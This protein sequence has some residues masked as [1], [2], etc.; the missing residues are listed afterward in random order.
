VTCPRA[1][2]C[3][4]LRSLTCVSLAGPRGRE[5]CPAVS[6]SVCGRNRLPVAVPHPGQAFSP[7]E[8][9][10]AKTVAAVAAQCLTWGDWR[11][12]GLIMRYGRLFKPGTDVGGGVYPMLPDWAGGCGAAAR[13]RAT[14]PRGT[15]QRRRQRRVHVGFHLQGSSMS[16]GHIERTSHP[17]PQRGVSADQ[18]RFVVR[19]RI[20]LSTFRFSACRLVPSCPWVFWVRHPRTRTCGISV[21]TRPRRPDSRRR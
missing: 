11:R 4:G 17:V 3:I 10:W 6:A 14:D 21:G 13:L 19:D 2:P 1:R 15:A 18:R 20:E 8:R 7:C 9:R 16:A 12:W 5:R